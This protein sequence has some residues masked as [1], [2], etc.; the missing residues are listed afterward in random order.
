M[1]EPQYAGENK[2]I[3]DLLYWC[4]F[5][6]FDL[7]DYRH[8]FYSWVNDYLYKVNYL[9]QVQILEPCEETRPG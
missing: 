7:K 1:A 3:D 6:A 8:R 5:S 4:Y 9:A 2:Y